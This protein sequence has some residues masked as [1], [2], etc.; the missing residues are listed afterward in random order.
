MILSKRPTINDLSDLTG[1]ATGT[2]SRYLNG[3]NVREENK[4]II[5]S[6]IKQLG[7]RVNH[8]ARS[9]KTRRTYTIG[10]LFPS[11]TDAFVNEVTKGV[12]DYLKNTDYGIIVGASSNDIDI[13]IERLAFFDEAMVDGIIIMPVSDSSKSSILDV[14]GDYPIVVIDKIIEGLEANYVVCENEE[15]SFEGV[16]KLIDD[17]HKRIG[18]VTGP[19]DVYTARERLNGYY[20][21]LKEHNIDIDES[22]IKRDKYQKN[23]GYNQIKEMLEWNNAPTA[24]FTT[25]YE[26]TMSAIKYCMQN[27]ISIGKDVSIL[28]YDNYD[29]FQMITPTITTIEQPMDEI[30]KQAA[31]LIMDLIDGK[32]KKRK[33]IVLKT[34]YIEGA[35]IANLKI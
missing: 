24:I 23:G 17:G 12:E 5:E 15:G 28:G 19:D 21:A 4:L 14:S 29:V 26:M 34:S 9:L 1:L 10:L 32:N 31:S 2:I 16:S 11:F 6:A 20:K 8:L 7:Y 25:N 3:Y 22:L 18:I 13:E 27:D 30:G 35:S 33:T